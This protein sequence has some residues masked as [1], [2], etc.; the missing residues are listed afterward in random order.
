MKTHWR[1]VAAL[2]VALIGYGVLVRAFHLMSQPS[3]Q[4]W[5]SGIA[6]IFGLIVVMPILFRA[7]WRML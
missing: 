5:Y 2:A 3:D 1:L 6:I 4:S 7:I